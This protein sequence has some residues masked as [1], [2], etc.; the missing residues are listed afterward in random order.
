MEFMKYANWLRFGMDP[1]IAV[2]EIAEVGDTFVKRKSKKRKQ[3]IFSWDVRSSE[4]IV[5]ILTKEM[6]GLVANTMLAI[7]KQME[8]RRYIFI[9]KE[10]SD[11]IMPIPTFA[12]GDFAADD[13]TEFI[14]ELTF[15]YRFNAYHIENPAADGSYMQKVFTEMAENKG[16]TLAEDL[17]I[18][19][20]LK[21]LV[22]YRRRAYEYNDSV[23]QLIDK[24]ISNRVDNSNVELTHEDFAFMERGRSKLEQS[25]TPKIGAIEL[26]NKEIY[27]ME[28]VKAQ[29]LN[30]IKRAEVAKAREAMGLIS[31]N[32]IGQV[33][34]FAGPP[35]T[36]KTEMA[37]HFMNI[38]KEKGIL[39]G[40]R[41]ISISSLHMK[42]F[43]VG[44][45]APK[46]ESIV[47]NHDAI[48][49]DEIY[50]LAASDNGRLDTFSQ[51]ALAELCIQLEKHSKDKLIIFAGYGGAV[52]DKNNKLKEFLDANPGISS[53][54][55]FTID[56]SM[57][58]CRKRACKYI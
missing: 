7:N 48:F 47:V 3:S 57:K 45:S 27:G 35:G 22:K 5:L 31:K 40:D 58:K 55:N 39:N 19:Y 37:K 33:Y 46:V 17:D 44:H 13:T 25:S 2:D 52:S 54:I 21:N 38:M 16:Y 49:I 24:V 50:A 4:P 41:F 20:V 12:M 26:M 18:K 10:V 51:E 32:V 1:E 15:K 42:G 43:Y 23:K 28:H 30:C 8:N 56:F 36:G 14:S 11:D 9:I 6:R 53:R 34:M 29:I